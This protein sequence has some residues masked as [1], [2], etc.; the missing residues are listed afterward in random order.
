MGGQFKSKITVVLFL[1]LLLTSAPAY[2]LGGNGATCNP[3]TANWGSC[4]LAPVPFQGSITN[5]INVPGGNYSTP[6][7]A[8]QANT[9]YVLQGDITAAN[10]GIVVSANYV[11]VDLN[12]Y[13]IT[14][15][16][17]AAGEGVTIGEYNLHHISVR[18]GSI[19]QGGAMSEGDL[20]G[21][22]NNP[23]GSYNTSIAWVRPASNM[24]V[25]NLYVR[26]GGRDVSGISCSGADGL[27]EQNTVEDTYQFG[28]LKDRH[29]G[30]DALSVSKNTNSTGNII[31]YNSII[32]AR[33]R[34][35]ETG[36]N[37]EVYGNHV[38]IR[39]IATNSV[40]ITHYAANN[41]SVHDNTVIGRGEHPIGVGIVQGTNWNVYNNLIDLQTT[42]LGEEYGSAYLADPSQTYI[43][44]RSAG[45]RTTW[46]GD[47]NYIHDN[48]ITI[49]TS[50][51]YV[52]TYSPTGDVAYVNGGGKGIFAG[53][54]ANQTTLI[55][56]N[57][58]SVVGDGT[59]T[60]G[61]ACS[62][63]FSDGLFF[64]NNKVT[65]NQNNIVIGDDYGTCDNYPL[66]KGNTLIKTG[67]FAGYATVANTYNDTGANSQVR[68]VDNVYQG[69]AS[70]AS[71]SL[72]PASA[73]LTDVYFGSVL[74]GTHLYSY[75]LHD[76]NGAS[77]AL[78]RDDFDPA[79]SLA[80]RYP[81]YF[82]PPI[83]GDG[84]RYRYKYYQ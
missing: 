37:S 5:T 45:F 80:Y 63:N 38:T 26:Y 72:M 64:I 81:D 11:I 53:L 17:S 67:S 3:S 20:Y 70:E 16:Q 84:K 60:I 23:V 73:G 79:I 61:M 7:Q 50:A 82:P 8:N 34:G 36:S 66:F 51:R 40:G 9:K 54:A 22:G 76:N 10:I 57:T 58:I 21:Q 56:N 75:R 78:I 46:G 28:T 30:I 77:T 2:P 15:N 68:F 32:N 31:R 27:Y 43:S 4:T 44:N 59:Y 83:A 12:G 52:G 25:A 18:N 35:I 13:T 41:V 39:S 69:G 6:Y 19:I 33:Q 29:Q 65:S 55:A 62:Y 42:A 47:K 48:T 1:L 71:I 24:H 49:T 14:Y 74:D